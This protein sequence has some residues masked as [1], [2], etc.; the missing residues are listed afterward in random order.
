MAT[1]EHAALELARE[2]VTKADAA[3]P[4]PWLIE[5]HEGH[6]YTPRFVLTVG[7]Q[8]GRIAIFSQNG[9]CEGNP[10]LAESNVEYVAHAANHFPTVARALL[11][12][13]E[14]LA[15]Y[16]WPHDDAD[17]QAAR[18]QAEGSDSLAAKGVYISALE[19]HLR[20][21]Q[22]RL[23]EYEVD[24]RTAVNT[25]DGTGR[26]CMALYGECKPEHYLGGSNARMLHDAAERLA[27]VER[28]RD[29]A[30][31]ALET[32]KEEFHVALSLLSV[33]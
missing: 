2:G 4:T 18:E 19:H 3:V 15:A 25:D 30:R 13:H 28:E 16:E 20:Q 9:I 21:A 22:E 27:E 29:E 7:G 26:L 10:E 17:L 23:A 11:A 8:E 33:G 5:Q 31:N 24:I 1:D 14:R 6:S 32:H 12:A